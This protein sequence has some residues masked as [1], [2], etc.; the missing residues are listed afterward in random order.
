MAKMRK[1]TVEKRARVM[2]DEV[3]KANGKWV[4]IFFSAVA[5]VDQRHCRRDNLT[6]HCTGKTNWSVRIRSI[7]GFF[8]AEYI[9]WIK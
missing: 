7:S 9:S 4:N 5:Q 1:K 3:G 8:T 6:R 2:S